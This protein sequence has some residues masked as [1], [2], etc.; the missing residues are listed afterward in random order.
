MTKVA[1]DRIESQ[2][3]GLRF[4]D[5]IG[6]HYHWIE[7]D[8]V[9]AYGDTVRR[10]G[11]KVEP[12]A[13]AFERTA[14]LSEDVFSGEAADM[15]RTRAGHRHE[16]SVGVRDDLRG[17]GRAINAYSDVLRRHRDGPRAAARLRRV[18]R[19][20][21]PRPPHLAAG[22]DPPRRRPAEGGR[23]VGARLEGLPAVLRR[24][25]RAARRP[26][27]ATRELVKA[28]ADHADVHPDKDGAKAVAAHHRR[29]E[30]GELRREAA[31]EA[32]EAVQAGDAAEAARHTVEVLKRRE[33][34]ALGDLEELVLAERP[35]AEIQAQAEKVAALHR[36]LTEARVDAREAEAVAEREQAQANRAARDLED[37]RGRPPPDRRPARRPQ[38]PA[39]LGAAAGRC[40]A[41]PSVLGLD[42]EARHR[43]V[44]H[45]AA[46][47]PPRVA[48]QRRT[49]TRT[50]RPAASSD[51]VV[52]SASVRA[53][54]GRTSSSPVRPSRRRTSIS[55][56]CTGIATSE[57]P[58]RW[59]SASRPSATASATSIAET[60]STRP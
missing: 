15:L 43:V 29:V 42:L 46:G 60:G 16:E 9:D 1:V 28:L 27:V 13:E 44:A 37:G 56:A 14:S 57:R 6:C 51:T 30:F 50:G 25:D 41:P 26:P 48:Q 36:E 55:A 52:R 11:S 8:A 10:V 4:G 54:V 34:A 38:G 47:Q 23:R 59:S 39:R 21:G 2:Q 22:R 40:A 3:D 31:E 24:Q 19:P 17:L 32:M 49:R 58:R 45:R 20:R 35:P 53:E 5:P 33:Q 12:A 18:G 7:P